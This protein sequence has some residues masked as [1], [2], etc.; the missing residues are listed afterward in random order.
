MENENQEDI[1]TENITQRSYSRGSRPPYYQNGRQGWN[2]RKQWCECVCDNSFPTYPGNR[3]RSSYP[4]RPGYPN[5]PR[6]P[7]YPEISTYPRFPAPP[8]YPG[9]PGYPGSSTKPEIPVVPP[10]NFPNAPGIGSNTSTILPNPTG[11]ISQTDP[12]RT[13]STSSPSIDDAQGL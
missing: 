13:T 5:Y 11:N 3:G 10:N 2:K 6:Y 4:E 9:N 8:G 1:A 7:S 12:R